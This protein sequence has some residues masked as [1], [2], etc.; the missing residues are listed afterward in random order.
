MKII[1]DLKPCPFC[2]HTELSLEEKL[3]TCLGSLYWV[4][5]HWC[6]S[7]SGKYVTAG[8]AKENWNNRNQ[9]TAHGE[10]K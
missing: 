3:E 6:E 10:K 2:G 4:W 1:T 9:T 7:R 8:L 5:C